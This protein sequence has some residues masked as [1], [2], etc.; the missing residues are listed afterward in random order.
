MPI[1]Y[2]KC[3]GKNFNQ[4]SSETIEL[5]GNM[6]EPPTTEPVNN[7]TVMNESVVAIDLKR[8]K[9]IVGEKVFSELSKFDAKKTPCSSGFALVHQIYQELS[10]KLP[11]EID[12]EDITVDIVDAFEADDVSVFNLDVNASGSDDVC[13]QSNSVNFFEPEVNEE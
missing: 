11:A 4:P 7:T 2:S 9:E 12:F 13:S 3:L 5:D 8:F 10:A 1:D 6:N